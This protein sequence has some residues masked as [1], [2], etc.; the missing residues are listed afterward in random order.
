[1]WLGTIVWMCVGERIKIVS[2]VRRQFA[3][4]S[5][6]QALIPL[7]MA[8]LCGPCDPQGCRTDSLSLQSRKWLCLHGQNCCTSKLHLLLNY[9]AYIIIKDQGELF[10][11]L[12]RTSDVILNCLFKVSHWHT[13]GL[14]GCIH[15]R[16]WSFD[17]YVPVDL[18]LISLTYCFPVTEVR[19]EEG[20]QASPWKRKPKSMLRLQCC[21]WIV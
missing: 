2:S 21:K 7:Q 15:V 4:C 3:F 17:N 5:G 13:C 6:A 10:C 19:H 1:M 12:S 9:S 18:S 14:R 8:C 20:K 16:L 11:F